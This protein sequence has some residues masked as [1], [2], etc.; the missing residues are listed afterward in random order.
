M[1]IT[2]L[3]TSAGMR[4]VLSADP[5]QRPDALRRMLAPTKG[6]FRYF[7][8]E[9]DLAAM[10]AMSLG[11]PID[12]HLEES[13][14]ALARLDEADA[15]TRIETSLAEAVRV[16]T[17]ALPAIVVP[18]ITVLLVLGDPGDDYFMGPARGFTGNGSMTG[19]IALTVW[20]T[21][22][23]LGRLEA[24]ATHE[25]HH[26]LR[27]A[28]GG[29]VWNPA[30]VM[31]GE[32]IV[33]EGLA[34]AFAREL[35]GDIGYTP[36]GAAH[37]H[38]DDVFDKVV[39]GLRVDGMQNFTAWVHGDEAARRFGAEL[40]GVPT[41][42]GYAVGNRLVDAFLQ[43]TGMSASQ[44]LHVDSHEVIDVALRALR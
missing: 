4:A 32:Q 8:D 37:L 3:D 12:R 30:S 11:F 17:A 19:F 6:M 25:L 2:V 7:S 31:V 39:S 43:S 16:Q 10:H 1:T 18:D 9:V 33:S 15:W 29:V 35:F 42:A 23:N 13:S 20:P 34:D 40:M 24:A 28:P 21:D 38:D 14:R 5:S 27:Y 22:E 41:G 36:M 44:A 26:N